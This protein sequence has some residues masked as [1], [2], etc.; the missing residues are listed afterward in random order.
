MLFPLL[1]IRGLSFLNSCLLY[2]WTLF[3][4]TAAGPGPLRL[5]L[6]LSS[7]VGEAILVAALLLG[8]DTVAGLKTLRPLVNANAT[9]VVKLAPTLARDLEPCY[10]RLVVVDLGRL[11]YHIIKV[12]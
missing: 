6:L 12:G 10:P 1:L 9:R 5:T 2:R 7:V 4:V 11:L 3:P 8:H